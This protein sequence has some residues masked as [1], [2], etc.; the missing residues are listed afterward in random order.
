MAVRHGIYGEVSSLQILLKAGCELHLIRSPVITVLSIYPVRRDLIAF[1]AHHDCYGSM[2]YSCIYGS[3]EYLL[4]LLRSGRC[5]DI[6]VPRLSSE[7]AVSHAAADYIGLI[8]C[9]LKTLYYFI[10]SLWNVY[11]HI[12]SLRIFISVK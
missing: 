3:P 11:S 9:C 8:A 2:L 6:P 12:S 1:L 10:C 7:Y 4:D 5:G